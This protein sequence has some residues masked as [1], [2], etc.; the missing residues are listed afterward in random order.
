[1]KKE[2][3]SQFNTELDSYTA[4]KIKYDASLT[5]EQKADLKQIRIEK[6]EAKEK[7]KHRQVV[8]CM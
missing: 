7:R 5:P 1:M 8:M 2:L 3:E 4:Q 6:R